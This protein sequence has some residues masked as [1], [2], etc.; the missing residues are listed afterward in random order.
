MNSLLILITWVV[1]GLVGW[2]SWQLL[3]QNG[4]LLLRLEELEERLDA[5][6]FDDEGQVSSVPPS[7]GE[8]VS[9]DEERAN[10]FS[11]RSLTR[12]KIK[13]DGL[14][15]GKPAPDFRLPCLD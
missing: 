13:R 8:G 9:H 14:K 12:S 7:N 5:M 2:L 11:D 15:A 3:R 6:E 4:R 10:R 1:L